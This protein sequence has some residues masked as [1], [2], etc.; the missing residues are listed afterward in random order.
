MAASRAAGP[1][2]GICRVFA[3]SVLGVHLVMV[4]GAMA[5]GQPGFARE[6]AAKEIT[7]ITLIEDHGEAAILPSERLHDAAETQLRAR[8]VCYAGRVD[9]AL[10]L[11]DSILALGPITTA[12][13]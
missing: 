7:T 2:T 13:R 10:A 1:I 12:K 11:Y 5:Q 9:E 6:C 4:P 3:A 8:S